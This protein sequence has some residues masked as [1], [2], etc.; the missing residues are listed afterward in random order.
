MSPVAVRNTAI[1]L[2]IAALALVWQTGF[3][4]ST[5]WIQRVIGIL[6]V[7]LIGWAVYRYFS[8]NRLAWYAIPRAQRYVFVACLAAVIALL[9][10][11]NLL[12]PYVGPFGVIV[13]IAG[14]VVVMIWIVRESRRL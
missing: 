14:L 4:V 6:F 13:L 7:L 10:A 5:F 11:G 9:L 2:G 1:V 3:G 12:S 8:Q